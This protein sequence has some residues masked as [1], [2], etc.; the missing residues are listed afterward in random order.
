MNYC[1]T[2]NLDQATSPMVP[3]V[4]VLADSDEAGHPVVSARLMWSFAQTLMQYKL[5][6]CPI[7]GKLAR[8]HHTS[9]RCGGRM[10]VRR[11]RPTSDHSRGV[12]GGV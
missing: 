9:R 4:M 10:A 7:G 5:G 6:H 8:I 12:T 11:R 3:E 1:W 2:A